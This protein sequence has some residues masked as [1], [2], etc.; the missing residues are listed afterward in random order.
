[1][2]LKLLIIVIGLVAGV[3]LVQQTQVFKPKAN[4][5]SQAVFNTSYPMRTTQN[6]PF[7]VFV[8]LCLNLGQQSP[9]GIWQITENLTAARFLY[10]QEEDRCAGDHFNKLIF[11][12]D[13]P[14]GSYLKL[15]A[16]DKQEAWVW[17]VNETSRSPII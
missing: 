5:P 14:V 4:E 16:E 7:G 15:C 3:Y 10:P 2:F 13:V 12:Q 8:S 1:M 6:F 9:A 11:S 17:R